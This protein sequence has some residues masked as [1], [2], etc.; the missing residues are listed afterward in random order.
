MQMIFVRAN[1]YAQENFQKLVIRNERHQFTI[2]L[3]TYIVYKMPDC[4]QLHKV[5]IRYTEIDTP[6]GQVFS[7]NWWVHLEELIG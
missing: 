5:L 4:L 1:T 3:S 2:Y 7:T 6:K